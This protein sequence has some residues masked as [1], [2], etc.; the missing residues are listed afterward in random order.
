MTLQEL[1][2]G[3]DPETLEQVVR[4]VCGDHRGFV[5]AVGEHPL[6]AE[7]MRLAGLVGDGEPGQ[8]AEPPA[9]E[10]DPREDWVQTRPG[11][12]QQRWPIGVHLPVHFE[13]NL[14]TDDAKV[15]PQDAIKQWD[16]DVTREWFRLANTYPDK[17]WQAQMLG[18]GMLKF[19]GMI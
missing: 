19:H 15:H 4:A 10:Y 6:T 5:K 7:L 8:E 18:F 2:P 12:W 11:A 16:P 3:A 13:I 1:V 17:A 14:T 9:P